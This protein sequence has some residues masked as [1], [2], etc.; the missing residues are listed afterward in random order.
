M[1]DCYIGFLSP[2]LD[3][4]SLNII[5]LHRFSVYHQIAGTLSIQDSVSSSSQYKSRL[6]NMKKQKRGLNRYNMLQ[7]GKEEK[8]FLYICMIHVH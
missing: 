2:F 8:R 6:K 5:E 7:D 4:I 3:S 1:E